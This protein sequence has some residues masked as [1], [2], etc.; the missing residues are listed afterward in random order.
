MKRV[1]F[2]LA[3]ALFASGCTPC[4]EGI[5]DVTSERRVQT[6]F[7]G[8]EVDGNFNVVVEQTSANSNAY[9]VVHAQEN[10]IPLVKAEVKGDVLHIGTDGCVTVSE[11][12][13]V[14]VVTPEL[15]SIDYSGS[16]NVNCY[17][18]FNTPEMNIQ[19][20]GSGELTF[21]LLTERTVIKNSGSGNVLLSGGTNALEVESSGSGDIKLDGLRAEDVVV[22]QSGSGDVSIQVGSSLDVQLS[23]SG[24][25]LYRGDPQNLQQ[26]NTGS[27]NIRRLS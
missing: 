1:L 2:A 7:T 11:P 19:L 6:P 8:I 23:G 27:G 14:V 26:K 9:I 4:V 21:R 5:G 10:V 16:G 24:N 17:M 18:I 20:S 15:T 13:K 25:V 3:I 12:L 22:K